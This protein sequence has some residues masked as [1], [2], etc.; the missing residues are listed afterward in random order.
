MMMNKMFAM[1]CYKIPMLIIS[2]VCSFLATALIMRITNHSYLKMCVH[3]SE[4]DH[5][6][7]LFEFS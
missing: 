2:L 1:T 5:H 6:L 4:T 3:Y 7:A